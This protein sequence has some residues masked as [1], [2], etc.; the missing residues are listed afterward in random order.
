MRSVRRRSF[1]TVLRR[2]LGAGFH[3]TAGRHVVAVVV[4][5]PGGAEHAQTRLDEV[6]GRATIRA[7]HLPD[8]AIV[9]H[10]LEH[11]DGVL[12]RELAILEGNDVIDGASC[13]LGGWTPTLVVGIFS[14]HGMG[15]EKVNALH[16]P[17]ALEPVYSTPTRRQRC[18]LKPA[19]NCFERVARYPE[20]RCRQCYACH[21]LS[22]LRW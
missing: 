13:V 9:D 11:G 15:W 12:L 20:R 14:F 2:A 1:A 5:V 8:T 3:F 16:E 17:L 4:A 19:Q 18:P 6:H 21:L 22:L 10:R 7:L